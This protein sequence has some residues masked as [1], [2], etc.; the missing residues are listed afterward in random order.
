MA[1]MLVAGAWAGF[2]LLW[3]MECMEALDQAQYEAREYASAE[4]SVKP[5]G[6]QMFHPAI[7]IAI[8][9]ALLTIAAAICMVLGP[10]CA[11][12]S[13]EDPEKSPT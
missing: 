1:V 8:G 6:P 10:V 12:A 7:A 3:L 9:F 11:I 13:G 5:A 4:D 2:G